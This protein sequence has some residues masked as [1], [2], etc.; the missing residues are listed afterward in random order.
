[1]RAAGRDEDMVD[2]VR[3]AVE[4]A[5]ERR[6]VIRVDDGRAPRADVVR[7]P[8]EPLL[9]PSGEDD[10]GALAQRASGG[11][12]ADPGT[13]ADQMTV[14]PSSSGSWPTETLV[15]ALFVMG[16][17]LAPAATV[18]ARRCP[19]QVPGPRDEDQ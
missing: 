9:I 3:Q 16:G 15:A 12:E 4:E 19:G 17:T 1:V 2:G 13:P 18:R 5:L 7:R 10:V 14:W 6:R 8:L 11:L